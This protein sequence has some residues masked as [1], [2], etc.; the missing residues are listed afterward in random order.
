M[1]ANNLS[2]IMGPTIVGNLSSNPASFLSDAEM[3]KRVMMALMDVSTE[4]WKSLIY[5]RRV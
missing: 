3:Q 2:T 1:T 5:T 4:H